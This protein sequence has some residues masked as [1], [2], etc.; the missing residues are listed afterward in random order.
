MKRLHTH[1]MLRLRA[2][3]KGERILYV[4]A[5]IANGALYLRVAEQNLHSAQ[6]ARLPIDDG[7]LGSAQRMGAVIIRAQSDRG[8]PFINKS[9]ILPRADMIGVIELARKD[10]LVKRAASS[11]SAANGEAFGLKNAVG[12]GNLGLRAGVASRA[13]FENLRKMSTIVRKSCKRL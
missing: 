12:G 7:R 9:S 10:E 11:A 3:S 5:Q 8:R 13:P 1:Q 2:L 4:D 6:V